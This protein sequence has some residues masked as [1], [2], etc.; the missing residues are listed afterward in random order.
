M[1]DTANR[2]EFDY[3][4]KDEDIDRAK[5]LVDMD[6]A[7]GPREHF[8]EVSRDGIQVR[9][10]VVAAVNGH[11]IRFGLT[12]AM[13][14]RHLCAGG[15]GV[16]ARRGLARRDRGGQVVHREARTA[17]DGSARGRPPFHRFS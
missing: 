11:A 1:T 12:Y 3:A 2:Q 16:P 14:R 10:P 7:G 5:T 17:L 15:P 6:V 13:N 9:K 4:I 8:S